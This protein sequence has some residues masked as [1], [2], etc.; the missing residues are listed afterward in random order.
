MKINETTGSSDGLELFKA[1]R[2]MIQD[3][4][5]ERKPYGNGEKNWDDTCTTM[6]WLEEDLE[7]SKVVL[8]ALHELWDNWLDLREANDADDALYQRVR[9]VLG[10]NDD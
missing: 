2:E 3:Y 7:H 4:E 6:A 10:Y 5:G 1:L 9:K 8:M